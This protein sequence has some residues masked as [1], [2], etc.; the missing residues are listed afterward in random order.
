MITIGNTP[1]PSP[2]T[3]RA[4][5]ENTVAEPSSVPAA[6]DD[7]QRRGGREHPK[8]KEEAAPLDDADAEELSDDLLL[9]MVRGLNGQRGVVVDRKV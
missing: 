3:P 8:E 1:P 2:A 5:A 9:K 4:G 6:A 7:K